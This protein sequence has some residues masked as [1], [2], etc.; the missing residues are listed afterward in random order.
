V[1]SGL[2]AGVASTAVQNENVSLQDCGA[3]PKTVWAV[4][5]YDQPIESF[6]RHFYVLI[7]GSDTNS[8]QPFV[9]TYPQTSYPTDKPRPQLQ[10]YFLTGYTTGHPPIINYGSVDD[11]QIWGAD[12]PS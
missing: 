12:T 4:D 5:I 9:L 10:V 1:D 8:S 7:N 3:S 6:F 2:R 11:D